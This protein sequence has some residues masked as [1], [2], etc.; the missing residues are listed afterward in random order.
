MGEFWDLLLSLTSREKIYH[1]WTQRVAPQ[2]CNTSGVT[3]N[4]KGCLD[5]TRK[6]LMKSYT[7]IISR[8]CVF[9]F[10]FFLLN[11]Q[12]W[13]QTNIW[14]MLRTNNW[15]MVTLPPT[16]A[17]LPRSFSCKSLNANQRKFK[18]SQTLCKAPTCKKDYAWST[19]QNAWRKEHLFV[20]YVVICR[21]GHRFSSVVIHTVSPES[22]PY[23]RALKNI[24]LDFEPDSLYKL[25][26]VRHDSHSAYNFFLKTSTY[27]FYPG[28]AKL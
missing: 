3:W 19:K 18:C 4:K 27:Y 16:C 11:L 13:Q 26:D 1:I 7:I 22:R 14:E 9:N 15:S 20:P 25:V 17:A 21:V 5:I 8:A 10:F 23:G 24:F 6:I 2:N 12:M 28:I